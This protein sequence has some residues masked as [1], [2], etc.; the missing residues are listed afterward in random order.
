MG[1]FILGNRLKVCLTYNCS[2]QPLPSEMI[3]S[4][5]LFSAATTATLNTSR[6]KMPQ[7]KMSLAMCIETLIADTS[8]ARSDNSG[9]LYKTKLTTLHQYSWHKK[10]TASAIN[11]AVKLLYTLGFPAKKET[12]LMISMDTK[13]L[14]YLMHT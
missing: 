1:T 9:F 12:S 11:I 13:R 14:R 2:S 6:T 5:E 8:G 3:L 7:E 10:T 4:K